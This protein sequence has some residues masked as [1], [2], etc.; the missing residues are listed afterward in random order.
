MRRTLLLAAGLAAAVGWP[1]PASGQQTRLTVTGFPIVFS[2]PTADDFD[3]G[4]IASG[5]PITF[6]IDA[7]T[8]GTT[9]RTTT[10]S[11]RCASPCPAQGNKPVNTLQ[12]RRA[13][14]ATWS[15][16][17]TTDAS[18]EA[19]LVFRNGTNDPW[20]N[21]VFFRFLLDWV[22]DPGSGALQQYNIIMTLTVTLP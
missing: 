21:S 13:D 20:S 22:G 15:A 14:L 6:T 18:I 16:L 9:Q 5:N 7:R 8:G 19:R 17:T 10:V 11:I 1:A 2:Q 12:W 3:A 4:S